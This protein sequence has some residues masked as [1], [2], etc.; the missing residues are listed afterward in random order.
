MAQL[1][2]VT[3]C[4]GRL[5]FLKQT[6]GHM[7]A[8]PDCETVLVDYSCPE[9]SGD[10]AEANLP[11]VRVLR[12]PGRTTISVTTA[13]NAGAAVVDTPWICFVDADIVLDPAFAA[14]VLPQVRPGN[15]YRPDPERMGVSGT[16]LVARADF[17]RAGGYDEALRSYGDDDYDVY[18]ALKFAGVRQ[19]RYPSALVTHLDHGHDLRTGRFEFTQHKA[20]VAINRLYRVVKWE[21]AR[22]RGVAL[23]AQERS[24]LYG[25]LFDAVPTALTPDEASGGYAL[26]ALLDLAQEQLGRLGAPGGAE[27]RQRLRRSILRP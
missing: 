4:M 5:A 13:R 15:F 12:I 26:E 24:R 14:T 18:D 9:H 25:E 16:F 17:A 3:V 6:L 23:S 8:Q 20:G 7:A 19:R 1:T 21:L 11:A 27:A 10:W 22:A 2:F